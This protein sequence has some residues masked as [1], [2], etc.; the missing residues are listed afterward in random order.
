M[1]VIS[2]TDRET[3]S[4]ARKCCRPA[5]SNSLVSISPR[6]PTPSRGTGQTRRAAPAD[7]PGRTA[8]A[9]P[10]D[11]LTAPARRFAEQ[12]AASLVVFEAVGRLCTL[13]NRDQDLRSVKGHGCPSQS[14][15]FTFRYN[16]KRW[17]NRLFP[18]KIRS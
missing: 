13:A 1:P 8:D 15:P 16:V 17:P 2:S 5:R 6:S 12:R 7:L 9:S 14:R 4:S 10:V 3:A 11:R 18:R